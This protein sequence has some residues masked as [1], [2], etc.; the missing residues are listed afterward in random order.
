M[1]F[2]PDIYVVCEACRGTRYNRETRTVR[3]RGFSISEVLEMTV[4][5]VCQLLENI[6]AVKSRLTTLLEVGLGYIRLGQSSP[7]LSGGEAQRVKLAA[8]LNR[9]S[10][11][12]TIYILDE[13]TTGLHFED[14]RHLLEILH[15]LVDRGNTVIVIEHNLEVVKSADWVIDLGPGGGRAGGTVVCSGPPDVITKSTLSYT[16]QALRQ[17]LEG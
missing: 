11:G 16:G 14:V 6:P 9:K 4:E 7:T 5:E 1:N 10:T 12:N 17:V 3:Y 13:P 2:L 15:R 8:E